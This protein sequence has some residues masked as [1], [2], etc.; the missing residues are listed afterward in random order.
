MYNWFH[1]EVKYCK[2]REVGFQY[3]SFTVLDGMIYWCWLTAITY[4]WCGER[5]VQ[6]TLTLDK[7]AARSS[8]GA[9]QTK[10][11]GLNP[12]TVARTIRTLFITSGQRGSCCLFW[13]TFYVCFCFMFVNIV[14]ML[15]WS[16]VLL[17]FVWTIYSSHGM[18]ERRN[19]CPF[20]KEPDLCR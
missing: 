18:K 1:F 16:C 20:H 9:L 15:C 5:F 4:T 10:T 12:W 14:A 17:F 13:W 7:E 3:N 6:N 11:K 2:K 19:K 8:F